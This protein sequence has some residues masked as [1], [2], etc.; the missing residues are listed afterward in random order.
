MDNSPKHTYD[1]K[2]YC[3][4]CGAELRYSREMKLW[5]GVTLM[6]DEK[7]RCWNKAKGEV[8]HTPLGNSE[9][10][11]RWAYRYRQRKIEKAYGD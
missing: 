4:I 10:L 6:K 8:E 1:D 7:S 2:I 5:I 11:D 3:D 9:R